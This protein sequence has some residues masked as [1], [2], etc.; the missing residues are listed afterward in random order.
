MFM[1]HSAFIGI[2]G[3]L[4]LVAGQASA[5]TT[6]YTT[7]DYSATSTSDQVGKSCK[8]VSIV[9]STGVVSAKC[10]KETDGVVGT[11]DTTFDMSTVT[12][13]KEN[14]DGESASLVW[15]SSST[16]TWTAANWT[17]GVGSNGRHYGVYVDCQKSGMTDSEGGTAMSDNVKGLKNDAGALAKRTAQ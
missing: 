10:N 1:K 13:C 9:S 17:A 7:N 15:G 5:T 6:T 4:L 14:D 16:T 3:T 2:V 8:E 12:Y 11:N